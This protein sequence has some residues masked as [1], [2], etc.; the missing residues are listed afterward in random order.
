MDPENDKR[1]TNLE[2]YLDVCI[3]QYKEYFEEN[4]LTKETNLKKFITEQLPELSKVEKN[5]ILKLHN[6]ACEDTVY[7]QNL[8]HYLQELVEMG[9]I[10]PGTE[11]KLF[12]LSVDWPLDM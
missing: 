6:S 9:K 3:G 10:A 5:N 11:D 12:V 2:Q 4:K 7:G 8:Y 1:F